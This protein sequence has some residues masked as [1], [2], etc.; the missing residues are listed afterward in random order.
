MYVLIFFSECF[1]K[2]K[3]MLFCVKGSIFI[4][5]L[6]WNFLS[7]IVKQ[8]YPR[9]S[10]HSFE[11][12]ISATGHAVAGSRLKPASRRSCRAT[13]AIIRSH[14][15]QMFPNRQSHTGSRPRPL[16]LWLSYIYLSSPHQL[17]YMYRRV[18]KK[19]SKNSAAEAAERSGFRFRTLRVS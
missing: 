16:L 12:S 4:R 17:M 19:K 5:K 2:L 8:T 15:I 10:N 14:K 6:N 7:M 9:Q 1:I 13:L 18:G 3:Y 11:Q